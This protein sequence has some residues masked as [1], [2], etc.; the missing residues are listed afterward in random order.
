[1][2]TKQVT[3]E[4]ST[5]DSF[6][7]KV[8]E[9]HEAGALSTDGLYMCYTTLASEYLVK[10][11]DAEKALIVLNRCPPEYFTDIIVPQMQKDGLFAQSVVELG[12]RLVQLGLTG[13]ESDPPNQSPAEA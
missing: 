12:Y 1:M 9:M 3:D 2:G 8:T 11:H 10:H 6:Q 7:Q 13:I 5:L 4:I